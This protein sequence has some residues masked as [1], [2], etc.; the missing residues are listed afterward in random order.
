MLAENIAGAPYE[1]FVHEYKPC[2]ENVSTYEKLDGLTEHASFGVDVTVRVLDAVNGVRDGVRDGVR[3]PLGVRV[4]VRVELAEGCAYIKSV[5]HSNSSSNISK[6][7][8]IVFFTN[9]S[10]FIKK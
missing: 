10:S 1:H 6:N 7:L 9:L 5:V 3:V 2:G 4:G 8:T